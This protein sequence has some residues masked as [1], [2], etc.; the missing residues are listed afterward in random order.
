MDHRNKQRRFGVGTREIVLIVVLLG[1]AVAYLGFHSAIHR[2]LTTRMFLSAESPSDDTFQQI[3]AQ[4][5]DP[6]QFLRRCWSTDKIPH[7]QLVARFLKDTAGSAP[8]WYREV[9]PLL[10]AGTMD[11]DMSVRELAFAGL[12]L[13]RDPHLYDLAEAQLKDVDPM[14]RLLGL[15]YL[16]GADAQRGVPVVVTLLDDPDLQVV[17]T[18]EAELV[19][20]TGEDYGVRLRLAMHSG[21]RPDDAARIQDEEKIRAGVTQRKQWWKEHAKEFP[22]R[23]VNLPSTAVS[24]PEIAENFSLPTPTGSQVSLSDYRGRVVLLNFWATWCTAC[25]A[26]IPEL[27]AL[28]SE[29]GERVG[30]IGV[31]LDGLPDEHHHPENAEAEA[32]E[33]SV[34]RS[35][36]TIRKVVAKAVGMRGINYT[37][38]LDPTGAVGGRFNGGELPTTV[39]IDGNGHVRRRFIGERSLAVFKAMVSEAEKPTGDSVA[40]FSR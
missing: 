17:T 26:E 23:V 5:R 11:P 33:H 39:I 21:S 36:D 28:H 7:R 8:E 20:W 15:Q 18:A 12:E 9:E 27:S 30:V 25:L 13:R 38:A 34:G 37:V 4:S 2:Y 32:E 40:T 10:L 24:V 14:V 6:A 22:S 3:L 1:V 19:R 31:S 35:L 16:R 29:L